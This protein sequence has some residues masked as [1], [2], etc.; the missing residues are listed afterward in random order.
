MTKRVVFCCPTT[1]KPF[2]PML[3]S[4][5]RSIP[6]I[7]RAGWAE[8]SV[9]EIGNPYISFARAHLLAKALKWEAEVVVFLDHDVSWEPEDLLTL[10]ETEEEV[11]A[12]TYRFKDA[13]RGE[14][15]YMGAV[16]VD[17]EGKPLGRIKGDVIY[18]KASA[19][20]AG[21]LK[22]TRS[23]VEHFKRTYPE[24]VFGFEGKEY[25]DLFGHGVHKKIWYGEDYAFSR[26][27]IDSGKELWILP[28]LKLGHWKD[29]GGGQLEAYPGCFHEYLLQRPGG[30]KCGVVQ[31]T[32][33]EFPRAV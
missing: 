33:E 29:V 17:A 25:V 22:V 19:V 27:W 2:G 16:Y 20:P 30:A 3:E 24:M 1:R 26:N 23:A 5:E 15:D 8:G 9:Y 18:L 28:Q 13:L 11:V 14:G 4:L 7:H 12:G 31:S 32:T 10:I 21:F 6:L